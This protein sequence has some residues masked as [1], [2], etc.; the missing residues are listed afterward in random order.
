MN[1]KRLSLLFTVTTVAGVIED[2]IA[3]FFVTGEVQLT[4]VQFAVILGISLT[5]SA[6]LELLLRRL[7]FR[8]L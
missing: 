2:C 6:I 3:V 8:E 5:S 4:L 7:H 1:W